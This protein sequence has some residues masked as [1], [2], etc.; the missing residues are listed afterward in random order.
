MLKHRHLVIR[1]ARE[2]DH[3]GPIPVR[4]LACFMRDTACAERRGDRDAEG[5]VG[6]LVN[7]DTHAAHPRAGPLR[8]S[9]AQAPCG[10]GRNPDARRQ[11]HAPRISRDAHGKTQQDPRAC[12]F[13]CSPPAPFRDPRSPD[14]AACLQRRRLAA[15]CAQGPTESTGC[16]GCTGCTDHQTAAHRP[17]SPPLFRVVRA[18][19]GPPPPIPLSHRRAEGSYRFTSTF[20]AFS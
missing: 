16:T 14:R 9:S 1:A 12:S 2:L 17:H 19:R 5:A 4:N 7:G 3:L 20:A 11:R 6:H 18:F 15:S 8:R 10:A 13:N